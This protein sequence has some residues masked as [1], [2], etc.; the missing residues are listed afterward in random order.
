MKND[1]FI[2][3]SWIINVVKRRKWMIIIPLALSI[4]ISI[5]IMLIIPTKYMATT[6]LMVEPSNNNQTNELN[7]LM[8]GER[9][10]QTY[11]QM[12]KSRPILEEVIT[13]LNA[14]VSAGDLGANTTVQP[15]NNTQLIR[16]S[17]TNNEAEQAV[18][19]A[20]TIAST[21]IS[22][23]KK[24]SNENYDQLISNNL[25]N[26]MQK[27]SEIDSIISN[28]DTQN[29]LKTDLEAE[30]SRLE[31]LLS[32]T[33]SSYL[34][35]QQNAHSL[36]L[37]VSESTNKVHVVE[38]AFIENTVSQP[39]FLA[40]SIVFFDLDIITG[41]ADLTTRISDLLAQIYGPMLYR[42]T[43]LNKVINQ[44]SLNES[45]DTLSQ[46]I[47]YEAIEGTQFLKVSVRNDD[48]SQATLIADTLVTNFVNQIHE[49]LAFSFKN[50]LD[51]IKSQ[52]NEMSTQMDK[53]QEDINNNA[54]KIIPI[55]LEIERLNNELSSKYSDLRSLQANND[56][57]TLEVSQAANSIVI[58]ES[59]AR[60]KN[61]FQEK[62]TYSGVLIL[63]AFIAGIG[64]VFIFEH[65]DD[66]VRSPE[67]LTSL[68]D[69][70]TINTIGQI[71]EG[72][73]RLIFEP[74]FSPYISEDFKKL[75]AMIRQPIKDFPIRS[76]LVTSPSPGEGKSFI[77]ANLAIILARTDLNVILVDADYHH[78]T[79]DILFN[80]DN[81][82]GLSEFFTTKKAGNYLKT[83]QYEK[84]RVLTTGERPDDP[85]SLFSSASLRHSIETLTLLTD[86][87]II[88]CP[89]LLTLADASY[90]TPIVDGV[91][92]VIRSGL[93]SRKDV[94][95]AAAILKNANMKFFGVVLNDK[96]TPPGKYSHYY[97]TEE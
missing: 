87:V 32:L 41:R 23:N 65:F 61:L 38:P 14:D 30:K 73:D 54:I 63:L 75:G 22:Y 49:N 82:G 37:T 97:K 5:L 62:V 11:T 35:L 80:L 68:L 36:E 86:V 33:K 24:L 50:K 20:N 7:V 55:D 88:D 26:S 39:P 57:L 89:P 95:D 67:E 2:N 46:Q 77:A 3:F 15:V 85:T 74:N 64:L 10:A 29:K 13:K 17:V 52:M 28:I 90:L 81:Q 60:A 12:I 71:G 18:A 96:E 58:S 34:T 21:F 43:L 79:M 78:P 4:I 8:A 42:E 53:N 93:T 66:K 83:T 51:N 47:T 70:K 25:K 69:I 84:L 9:L 1:L 59:A 48:S 27:Q 19:F 92:L 40:T 91:I 45:S 6:T 76:L 94:M 44:L 31:L 16:I 72:K 56:Q